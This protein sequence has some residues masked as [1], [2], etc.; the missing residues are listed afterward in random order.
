MACGPGRGRPSLLGLRSHRFH[1]QRAEEEEEEEIETL[2]KLPPTVRTLPPLLLLLLLCT[3]EARHY[4]FSSHIDAAVPPL[5]PRDTN[6][7]YDH[8][9]S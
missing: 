4:S 5:C 6:S 8:I 9:L 7:P 3:G 1:K 2:G